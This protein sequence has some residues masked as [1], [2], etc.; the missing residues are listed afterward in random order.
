MLTD[1]KCLEFWQKE[2]LDTPSGPVG[3]RSRWHEL[4]SRFNIVVQYIP[5]KDNVVADALSRWAYSASKCHP[6]VSHNGTAEDDEEMTKIEEQ[7]RKEEMETLVM[8]IRL[9]QGGKNG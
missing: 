3:R 4:L 5:G 7:E 1:H 2:L 9:T 6:D 8:P